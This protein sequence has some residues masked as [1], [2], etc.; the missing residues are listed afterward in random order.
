VH[1]ESHSTV[2]QNFEKELTYRKAPDLATWL[3]Y[4]P[5]GTDTAIYNLSQLPWYA[6]TEEANNSNDDEEEQDGAT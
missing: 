4:I 3:Q 5:E 6:D 1:W 2:Q